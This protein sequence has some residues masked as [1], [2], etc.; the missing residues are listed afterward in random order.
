MPQ[1]PADEDPDSNVE[2][3]FRAL[4]S[5][6]TPSLS[7]K[8]SELERDADSKVDLKALTKSEIERDAAEKAG[9]AEP[10]AQPPAS[11]R[12]PPTHSSAPPAARSERPTPAPVESRGGVSL[13]LMLAG[14]ALAGA[15]AYL[16]WTGTTEAAPEGGSDVTNLVALDSV[17]IPVGRSIADADPG[18]TIPDLPDD[19][20]GDEPT[21]DDPPVDEPVDAP[22]L[23]PPAAAI[24]AEDPAPRAPGEPRPPGA[25][26]PR[27]VDRPMGGGEPDPR[28]PP[29]EPPAAPAGPQVDPPRPPADEPPIGI[30]GV[31]DL[32]LTKAP[33]KAPAP[34]ADPS[35]LA[36][37]PSRQDVSRILG[38]LLPQIRQ[39]AGDQV[40]L[41]PAAVLVRN[42][43]TVATVS[44]G[45]SPFGGTPQGRCMEGVVRSAA[46]PRFRQTTFRITYP[47][48]IRPP[49]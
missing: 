49:E 9:R 22:P 20:E 34:Q 48:S 1:P 17:T 29:G 37:A 27:G 3:D 23:P 19:M 16:Y 24:P 11:E 33:A 8:M 14:L 38:G 47:F 6:S 4:A 30:D 44:V 39:C 25:E 41:A 31:L 18:A 21:A 2:L 13:L 42:D 10:A 28:R 45:G 12:P 40:G 15:G 36:D 35:A 7:A 5:S 46:F 32:A 26:P 43:G